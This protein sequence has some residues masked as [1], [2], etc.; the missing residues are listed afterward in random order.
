DDDIAAPTIDDGI[1]LLDAAGAE[2]G[3]PAARAKADDADLAVGIG[4]GAQKCHCTGNIANDLVVRDAA[5]RA[6]PS[7]YIVRAP[8]TIAEIKMRGNRRK[9]VMRKLADHLDDPFIPARQVVDH[10]DPRKLF[11]P[12]W[13][14][15]IRLAAIS[16]MAG[17]RDGFGN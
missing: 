6:Y 13:T 5:R 10:D 15:I 9:T 1:D 16:V 3:M 8:G 11:A 2:I 12:G 17:E 14:G 4:L 7:A